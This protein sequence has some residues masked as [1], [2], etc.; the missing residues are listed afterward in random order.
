[1]EPLKRHNWY[2]RVE[3]WDGVDGLVAGFT[4]KNDQLN[5]GLHVGDDHDRVMKNRQFVADQLGFPLSTWICCEQTHQEQITRVGRKEA[6]LGSD[7][8]LASLS[9]TDG[10]YTAESGVLLTMCYADCVPIYFIHR[11]TRHIGLIHAGWR[12]TTLGIAAKMIATWRDIEQIDPSEIEVVIGPAICDKCYQVDH[13][14]IRQIDQLLGAEADQVYKEATSEQFLLDLK[15][16]NE[17][18]IQGVK[19]LVTTG[20][21]TCCDDALFFSHRRDAGKT[22]RMMAFMGWKED[23]R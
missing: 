22:G 17:L 6:G 20:Y 12:G 1:M 3:D 10:I 23:K 2:L 18:V 8:Y 14:V 13:Q 16:A 15:R 5:L 19:K 7:S 4:L 11:K 9:N 21:C